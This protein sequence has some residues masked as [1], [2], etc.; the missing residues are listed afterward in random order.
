MC[1][2]YSGKCTISN[3]SA[4]RDSN[5]G[6]CVQSCRH[7]YDLFDPETKEQLDSQHIMNAKDLMGIY[8]TPAAIQANIA[9]LKIEGR[10][11]SNLY[12]AN[13]VRSYRSAIDYCYD[14][15][16]TNQEIDYSV[17]AKLENQLKTVSNRDFSTGGLLERPAGE[18]IHY[19]FGGY[20]KQ[21][22]YVG[23][24]RDTTKEKIFIDV[25][26]HFKLG[27]QLTILHHN[28]S[29]TTLTPDTFWNIE[30]N[31]V[32]QAQQNT[33]IALPKTPNSK[34][35]NVITKQLTT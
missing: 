34:C 5:R 22:D 7:K 1:A 24:I 10:M 6:G 20:Q 4:G 11:K 28:G 30:G 17:L 12:V 27:D 23:I 35:F 13:A 31:A 9:S 15:L 14:Q 29:Q 26:N 2:S 8:Q 25:K 32:S 3:I 19:D 18:S 21:L 33:I 16:T